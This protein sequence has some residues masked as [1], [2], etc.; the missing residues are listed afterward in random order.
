ME[1][2]AKMQLWA[3]QCHCP[4]LPREAMRSPD[5][6]SVLRRVCNRMWVSFMLHSHPMNKRLGIS[7][8]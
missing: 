6:W 4:R 7:L 5:V 8:E 2:R 3:R 1:C